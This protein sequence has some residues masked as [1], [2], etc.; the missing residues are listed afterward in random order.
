M[1]P[2]LPQKPASSEYMTR[3]ED[4]NP[5]L[6]AYLT[7]LGFDCPVGDV[8]SGV[9]HSTPHFGLVPSHVAFADGIDGDFVRICV[10]APGGKGYAVAALPVSGIDGDNISLKQIKSVC[11]NI[12]DVLCRIPQRKWQNLDEE[13]RAEVLFIAISPL[14]MELSTRL[15]I[16]WLEDA[17]TLGEA[18]GIQ[19]SSDNKV[20]TKFLK[21]KNSQRDD[22]VL[23]DKLDELIDKFK[24]LVST[25]AKN[26][27]LKTNG[28]SRT[29]RASGE[30]IPSSD[31]TSSA[32]PEYKLP[33]WGHRPPTQV[34]RQS[35]PQT[36]PTPKDEWEAQLEDYELNG[37]P[38]NSLWGPFKRNVETSRSNGWDD[39]VVASTDHKGA[40]IKYKAKHRKYRTADLAACDSSD[41]ESYTERANTGSAFWGV[42]KEESEAETELA[43]P[44]GCSWSS[45]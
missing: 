28:G 24:T 10:A 5:D 8:L 4:A 44:K 30:H 21:D 42:G 26:Q 41:E 20:P 7:R 11:K 31:E 35:T 32:K 29:S 25:V 14:A 39:A 19:H 40:G 12:G 43:T 22:A 18:M 37:P 15:R 16:S 3:I 1:N 6:H 45:W 36:P 38:Q 13:G 2:Y 9:M 17:E 27:G 34:N 23:Q 33:D